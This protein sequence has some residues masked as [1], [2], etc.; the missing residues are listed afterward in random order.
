MIISPL[1]VSRLAMQ[2]VLILMDLILVFVI[3]TTR[4]GMDIE[5]V[6]VRYSN[7]LKNSFI[8][9]LHKFYRARNRVL[10]NSLF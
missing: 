8:Y 2:L 4:M 1:L 9:R 6:M 10:T 7:S 5:N 3:P